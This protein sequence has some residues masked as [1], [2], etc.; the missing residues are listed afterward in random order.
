VKQ[1]A[2]SSRTRCKEETNDR[3]CSERGEVE[4]E[5]EGEEELESNN[6]SNT[7]KQ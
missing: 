4:E 5:E 1:T 3:E 2:G 7:T 6:R